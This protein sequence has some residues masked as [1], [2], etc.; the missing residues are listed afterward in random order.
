[1]PKKNNGAAGIDGVTFEAIAESGEMG[2][3]TQ[4]RDELVTVTDRPMRV[5]KKEIPKDGARKSVSFRF[6]PS[7]MAW[8]RGP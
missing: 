5:R 3:L 4:I 8:S 2:F 6:L 7:G 1:M